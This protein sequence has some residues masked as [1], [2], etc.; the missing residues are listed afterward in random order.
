M[1]EDLLDEDGGL[2]VR[3]AESGEHGVR[4]PRV[5]PLVPEAWRLTAVGEHGDVPIFRIARHRRQ[6]VGA[7]GAEEDVLEC[8]G[9]CKT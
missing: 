1:A 4:R 2:V 6:R 8:G 7:D 9:T 5:L 3:A